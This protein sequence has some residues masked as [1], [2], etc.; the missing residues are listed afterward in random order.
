M[1]QLIISLIIFISTSLYVSIGTYMWYHQDTVYENDYNKYQIEKQ[2]FDKTQDSSIE[3]Q[4]KKFYNEW[5]ANNDTTIRKI[6]KIEHYGG[7]WYTDTK[8][9]VTEDASCIS[10]CKSNYIERDLRTACFSKCIKIIK[11]NEAEYLSK[12]NDTI[13]TGGYKNRLEWQTK[14]NDFAKKEAEKNRLQYKKYDGHEFH[15]L[16]KSPSSSS[17]MQILF[18]IYVVCLPAILVSLIFVIASIVELLKRK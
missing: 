1:K 4:S 8:T 7:F 5:I 18:C 9:S 17:N 3:I 11:Y 2:N 6:K 12:W 14:A 16:L 10:A 13:W 15:Y